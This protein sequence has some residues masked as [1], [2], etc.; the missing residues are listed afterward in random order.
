MAD[1][2]KVIKGLKCCQH[3]SKSR[4]DGCPYVYEGLCSTNDCTAD[5]A[6]DAI[7]MLKEQEAKTG[8]WT[9]SEYEYLNCS[10]CGNSYYTGCDSTEEA[11]MRLKKGFYFKYCPF[12][13]AKMEWR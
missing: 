10:R 11:K 4:C 5:L 9:I 3:S 2:E 7:A 8:H 12:C 13:G 1:I 6:S